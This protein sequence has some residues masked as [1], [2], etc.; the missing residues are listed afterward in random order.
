MM[1]VSMIVSLLAVTIGNG[2]YFQFPPNIAQGNAFRITMHI[3]V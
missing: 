2:G 1:G 3:P